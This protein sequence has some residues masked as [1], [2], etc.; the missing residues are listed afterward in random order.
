[1][2][3]NSTYFSNKI[4]VLF[5]LFLDIAGFSLIFPLIPEIIN[6][7]LAY[8]LQ[9]EV[10]Q[11]GLHFWLLATVEFF[12][13][14]LPESYRTTDTTIILIGGILASSYSLAQFIVSPYWGKLSDRFGRKPILLITS[15]GFAL[16]Y[17]LW[18]F[19]SSFVVFC[20][21]RLLGG[22]MGGNIGVAA[23]AMADMSTTEKRVRAM[24][25]VGAVMGIGFLFGPLIG[26][27]ALKLSPI[28]VGWGSNP[29][30]GPI[31]VAFTLASISF[32]ANALKLQET[33][34]KIQ[35]NLSSPS[36]KAIENWTANP[37]SSLKSIASPLFP[38]IILIHFIYTCIFAAYQFSF[39]FYY[40]FEFAMDGTQIGFVFFYVG[41][42]FV[43]GQGLLVRPLSRRLSPHILLRLGLMVIP[44]PL[45]VFGFAAPSLNP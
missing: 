45:I 44:L 1:M 26:G 21:A 5:L 25:L 33:L 12:A 2:K 16:S 37:F 6:Y 40:N 7:Y 20:L 23:A 18:F 17:L 29:F 13:Q 31:L 14:F 19:S 32:C 36:K 3:P 35:T 4:L 39:S 22:L 10:E 27:L 24:G 9:M 43:L 11:S 34:P 42:W 8:A 30:N 15:F 41:C 38:R 28:L